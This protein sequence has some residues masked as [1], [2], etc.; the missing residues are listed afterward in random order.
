MRVIVSTIPPRKDAFG[1]KEHVLKNIESL[2]S[3]IG[4]LASEQSIGF[5]DTHKA[6]MEYDPPDGWMSLL[7]DM[8]G[9]HPSPAG[10]LVIADLF[11]GC[12]A[13]FSPGIPSGVEQAYRRRVLP[14][15]NRWDPCCESDFAFFRLEFG[16]TIQEMTGSTTTT[17][18]SFS[19]HGLPSRDLYFRIRTVDKNGHYSSFTS[20]YAIAVRDRSDQRRRRY[21]EFLRHPLLGGRPGNMTDPYRIEP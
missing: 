1:N 14:E 12:L 10:Q 17:G 3:R 5:I 16:P 7:E 11:A 13:A 4:R 18:S 2:N 9:N 19:F 15:K 20:I 21:P 6:F 8:G